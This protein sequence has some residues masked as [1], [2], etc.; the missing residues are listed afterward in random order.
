MDDDLRIDINQASK[1]ELQ[2]INDVADEIADMIIEERDRRGGFRDIAELDGIHG[3]GDE[4]LRQLHAHTA[5]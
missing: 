3:I 4:A 2:T 5:T 1:H